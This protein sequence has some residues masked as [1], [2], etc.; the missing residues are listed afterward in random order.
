MKEYSF[1]DIKKTIEDNQFKELIY[2]F[3]WDTVDGKCIKKY[4]RFEN[5][6]FFF[7]IDEK[8]LYKVNRNTTT[9]YPEKY[10]TVNGKTCIKIEP[11]RRLKSQEFRDF[12]D[13][14][15]TSYESDV[16]ALTR[17][18]SRNKPK[19][20]RNVRKVYIDIE[21]SKKEDGN[22]SSVEEGRAPIVLIT[23]YDNFEDKYTTF[24]FKPIN[25]KQDKVTFIIATDEKDMLEKFTKYLNNIKPDYLLGWN[26]ESYDVPYIFKRL[27]YWTMPIESF[28]YMD[29]VYYFQSEEGVSSHRFGSYYINVGGTGVFDLMSAAKRLWLGK[30]CGYSLN[31]MCKEYLKEQKIDLNVDQM[32]RQNFDKLVEYNIKDVELCIKLDNKINLFKSF[33]SFQE[34]ISINVHNTIIQ[35]NNIVQYLLQNTNRILLNSNKKQDAQTFEGGMVLETVPGIYKKCYKYDFVSMYPSI[36]MTYNISPDTIIP[37]WEQD[38]ISLDSKFF[39][40]K[41]KGIISD[42][43]GKLFEKR[44]QYKKEGN[45]D[46]S[47]A[48]KLL[49]NS[50]YGQFTAPYSRIF[51]FSCGDAITYQ[52]RRLL[53]EL[54]KRI[55]RTFDGKIILGDTD[56]II[57]YTNN[58]EF[59]PESVNKLSQEIF[60]EFYSLDNIRENKFIKLEL[61][62]TIDKLIIF[63]TLYKGIKKK[64]VEHSNGKSR[65]VGL[66]AI[67]E[68]TPEIAK[69]LQKEIINFII[70]N[71]SFTEKDLNKILRDFN[72]KFQEAMEKK[73]FTYIAIP[74]KINKPLDKY[75]TCTFAIKAIQNGNLNVSINERFHAIIT[76]KGPVGFINAADLSKKDFILDVPY[77]WDRIEKKAEL[78]KDLLHLGDKKEIQLDLTAWN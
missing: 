67:K 63:G 45:A 37:R 8:E 40:K 11:K 25:Y 55:E 41:Q 23:C 14:F 77:M 17:W 57:Y 20:S 36:I 53:A 64:Y 22:Y 44:L 52:A 66:D 7:Y 28:S 71:D 10:T 73:D 35:S 59:D 75:K 74:V 6:D 13:L 56:S 38:C 51:S 32:Y 5:K 15:E 47:L 21:T 4:D 68:D 62:K 31:K 50:I 12:R 3:Y 2:C 30:Y 48:Y 24:S 61:E 33:Q 43:I 58:P 29:R 60:S 16:P 72:N 70:N 26:I 34:I 19:Y 49:M 1:V 39:F 69:E 27:E 46:L 18:I 78:F 76:I 65:L 9:V 54:V 42:I